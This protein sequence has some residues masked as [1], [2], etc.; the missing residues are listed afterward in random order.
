MK[1][2]VIAVCVAAGLMTTACVSVPTGPSVMVLPGS[3]KNFDQFQVDDAACRQWAAQQTGTTT[4]EASTNTA[5]AGAAI[6]TVLG[7]AAGA[8]IG[9]AAGS[10]G[11][12]AAV[13]AGVGLLGGSAVGANN[14]YAS[15]RTVQRRYD[16]SYI[17]CMYAKGNQVPVARGSA[18][19]YAAP[20]ARP[21]APPPPP[22]PPP[23]ASAPTPPPPPPAAL[24]VPPPPIGPPP[25]PPPPTR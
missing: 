19:A 5:V 9:A 6:G 16:A 4:N 25:P 23:A 15:G 18:P 17:Q 13:G 11:T 12:G 21:A 8:A 10:P 20:A 22:P 1:T 3:G 14:A 7:A 24:A 2:R